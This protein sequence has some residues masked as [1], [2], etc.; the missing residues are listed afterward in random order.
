MKKILSVGLL[1]A[2]SLLCFT[3]AKAQKE[4]KKKEEKKHERFKERRVSDSTFR[5]DFNITDTS[6][7]IIINRIQDINNAL[8]DFSDVIGDGFDSSD[9]SDN[10]PTYE[11]SLKF[12]KY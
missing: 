10:L 12:I 3:P 11:R 7:A 5:K 6:S 1:V 4:D 2:V 8:N 9:I